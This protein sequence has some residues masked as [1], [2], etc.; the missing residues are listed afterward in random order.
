MGRRSYGSG[1]LFERADATGRVSWYGSWWSGGT[2]VK[3]KIAAK[4]TPG[5]ADGLTRAQAEKE[6]RKRIE[7]DVI[8]STA[9]RRTL[10]EAGAAYVDHLEHVMERKRSTIQDYR[11]ICAATSSR[12]SASARSTGSTRPR[13]RSTSSAS[14]NDG[15]SS[16]TVQNHLNF[17]HGVFAFAVKRGWA[18]NNPV[19]YVDRPKKNRSPHQRVRFLQ[20]P[21]LDKLIVA[22]PEDTLGGIEGVLYLA[23]ALTG[24]RQG[25]LLALKW[26]DIDRRVARIRVADNF[27]RGQMDTPKSHEGRSVPMAARLAYEL[28]DLRRR[29]RFPTDRDLVFCHPETGRVLDPSKMRKRFKDALAEAGVREITFHELRHTFGTQMPPP[30]PRYARS[31]S[32]WATPTRR[33]PRSTGTTR[34]IR[35]ME[36]RSL[37]GRLAAEITLRR[38]PPDLSRCACHADQPVEL[39]PYHP[40][41]AAQELGQLRRLA[42]VGAQRVRKR[43]LKAELAQRRDEREELL[44]LVLSV[45]RRVI[46]ELGDAHGVVLGVPRA[47]RAERFELLGC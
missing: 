23:A 25:E 18:Q 33:P 15:L 28:E 21:E 9:A 42:L 8:V 34:P 7:R 40:A 47:S 29:S 3:R 41:R 38:T 12:S 32:G 44:A 6:L 39:Y 45:C 1:R 17:L 37:N 10:E 26:L 11:G 4:R 30:A 20:P 5:T 27:T 14:A 46:S 16:K 36:R 31:R 24:L 19:A 35:L 13:W 22:V 43:H 2:R